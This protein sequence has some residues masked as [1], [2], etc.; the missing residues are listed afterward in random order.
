MKTIAQATQSPTSMQPNPGPGG[1]VNSV[2]DAVTK[3]Q[4]GG[5]SI[6]KLGAGQSMYQVTPDGTAKLMTTA[7]GGAAELRQNDKFN[8]QQKESVALWAPIKKE[9]NHRWDKI[10]EDVAD[11]AAREKALRELNTQ[12]FRSLGVPEELADVPVSFKSFL[13]DYMQTQP[14]GSKLSRE[15]TD[16]L[17]VQHQQ[18][19]KLRNRL[20]EQKFGNTLQFNGPTERK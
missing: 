12:H 18:Y 16:Q 10:T 9:Y 17:A 7:P 4:A 13:S 14:S 3:S 2:Q 5:P 11:P 19:N 1:Q 15:K 6:H 20:L 8:N